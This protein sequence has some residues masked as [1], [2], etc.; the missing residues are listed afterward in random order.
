[1]NAAVVWHDVECGSYAADLALWRELAAAAD[2]RI[3]DLGAGTGRVAL[4]LAGLGSDVVALD[5]DGDLLDELAA[6]A[7][8][9]GLIVECVRADARELSGD[10][11]FA[12]V[13]APMQLLQVVGGPAGRMAILRGAA[14]GLAP[15]GLFA[16]AIADVDDSLP[17]DDVVPP[18]PD[19]GEHDG[20]VYSSQPVDVRPRA[21]GVAVERLRQRVSPRGKLEQERHTQVLDSLTVQRLEV[22]AAGAGL[23]PIEHHPIPATADHIG[24]MV[25]VCRR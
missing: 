4:D 16:A 14:A 6:R 23:T 1:M 11:S 25:V 13:L 21:G 8:H 3:L 17:T 2:G 5:V 24:S 9:R 7:A 22:E 20:W 15:G 19:M 10:G 12:L 18:V